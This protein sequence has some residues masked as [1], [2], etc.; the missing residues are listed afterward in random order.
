MVS[1]PY[2]SSDLWIGDKTTIDFECI[3]NC[4]GQFH[5]MGHRILEAVFT[6]L[7]LEKDM[8]DSALVVV[9]GIRLVK[10]YSLFLIK[11]IKINLELIKSL[12]FVDFLSSGGI[13]TLLNAG[14]L[15][16]K[17]AQ[18]APNAVFKVV[19][20]SAWLLE[21]PYSYLCHRRN[22]KTESKCIIDQIFENAIK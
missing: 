22:G 17:V 19:I 21:L 16:Q 6:D 18:M 3:G 11:L 10:I 15:K 5:F 20:D 12:N 1:I 7:M 13:G 8:K 2:C 4:T 14:G 9:A